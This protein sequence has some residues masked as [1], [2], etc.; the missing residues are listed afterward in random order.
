[1]IKEILI[2]VGGVL[3]GGG[4]AYK[5]TKDKYSAIADDEIN[6]MREYYD[7]KVKADA[8]KEKVLIVKEKAE[9]EAETAHKKKIPEETLAEDLDKNQELAEGNGYIS[10]DSVKKEPSMRER[11]D[12]ASRIFRI[13]RSAYENDE[14]YEKQ[15]LIYYALDDIL[16][17][18]R[19]TIIQN[20][21][22]CIDGDNLEYFGE[23]DEN[24]LFVRNENFLTDYEVELVDDISFYDVIDR[25]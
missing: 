8:N 21:D 9:P 13:S 16:T 12:A 7:A 11:R 1:M 3:V 19:N 4:V 23:Y 22:V 20:R 2:F 14:T 24:Y 25:G 15:R 17:D 18:E 10:Y 6:E 5:L